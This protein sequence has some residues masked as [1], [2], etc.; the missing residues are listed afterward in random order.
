MRAEPSVLPS[1]LVPLEV[2]PRTYI[3]IYTYFILS[4]DNG[5][6][7]VGYQELLLMSCLSS[8]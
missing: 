8:N 6:C 3:S 4:G 2:A 7:E 1:I 5:K